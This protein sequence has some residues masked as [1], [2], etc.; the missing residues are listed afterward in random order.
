[1]INVD[2]HNL[3]M[4]IYYDWLMWYLMTDEI[5]YWSWQSIICHDQYDISPFN[6]TGCSTSMVWWHS[7]H[8]GIA[9]NRVRYSYLHLRWKCWNRLDTIYPLARQSKNKS[10]LKLQYCL[11]SFCTTTANSK[12]LLFAKA[13]YTSPRELKFAPLLAPSIVA[14]GIWPT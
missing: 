14:D 2:C 5:S 8:L 9:L 4:M 13:E 12:G 3:V 10:V 6:I 7:F 1:M 11:S